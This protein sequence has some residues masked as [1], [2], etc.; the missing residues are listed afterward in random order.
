MRELQ[1]QQRREPQDSFVVPNDCDQRLAAWGFPS[2]PTLSRVYCN[3]WFD[4][5]SADINGTGFHAVTHPAIQREMVPEMVPATKSGQDASLSIF[6]GWHL[7]P[8]DSE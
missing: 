3:A 1:L 5:P 8:F 6:G 7:F 4:R 2:E